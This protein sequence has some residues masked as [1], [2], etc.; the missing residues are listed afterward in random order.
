MSACECECLCERVCVSDY[1]SMCDSVHVRDCTCV[2]I[3]DYLLK[4]VC[5]IMCVKQLSC[6]IVNVSVCTTLI[7]HCVCVYHRLDDICM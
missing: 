4:A 5:V 6:S 7:L 2:C 3:A 1:V